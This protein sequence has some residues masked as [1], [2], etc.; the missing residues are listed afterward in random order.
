MGE[1]LLDPA[2]SN[3][4]VTFKYLKQ[5]CFQFTGKKG[6]VMGSLVLDKI[7]NM[8]EKKKNPQEK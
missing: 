3:L 8:E 1:H 7:Y 6:E 4:L 2:Y 5:P